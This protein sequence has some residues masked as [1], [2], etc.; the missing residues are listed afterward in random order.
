MERQSELK[1]QDI[2]PVYYVEYDG[3]KGVEIG[4][5]TTLEGKEGAVLQQVGTKV[6][7]VYNRERLKLLT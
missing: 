3:F 4:R 7:H 2:T 6:V 1:V 5:Y